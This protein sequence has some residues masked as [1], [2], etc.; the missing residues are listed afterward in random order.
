MKEGIDFK[1]VILAALIR[2]Y[3]ASGSAKIVPQVLRAFG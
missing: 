3:Y 2:K 1:A